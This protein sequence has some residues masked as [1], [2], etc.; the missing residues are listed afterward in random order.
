MA[1]LP[2]PPD[3]TDKDYASILKR[4]QNLIVQVFARWTDFNAANFGNILLKC[5]AWVG[6][7]LTFYQDQQARETRWSTA[8]QRANIISHAKLID[9]SLSTAAAATVLVD[10]TITRNVSPGGK[11]TFPAGTVGLTKNITDP[12]RFQ[13]L[14]ALEVAA[15][16]TTGQVNFEH[17]ESQT[18]PFT[19]KG[20]K[21]ET[22]VLT[23]AP[24]LD[25]SLEFRVDG[26]L[27]TKV[28]NFL[29]STPTSTHY[30]VSVDQYDKAT[31]MTGDG[32][33][34]LV[35]TG[36]AAVVATYKTGGGLAGNVEIGALSRLEI[37]SWQDEYGNPVTVSI[38]NAAAASGGIDRET[39]GQANRQ[40]PASIRVPVSCVAR[41]DFEDKASDVAG[42]ARALMLTSNEAA[43]V[44]E[45][46]GYMYVVPTG[47]GTASAA[48]LAAVENHINVNYPPMLT[49]QW[50]AY[51]AVYQTVN[52]VVWTYLE[53]GA[54][55]ATVGTA[56]RTVLQDFF[57]PL[58][59]DQTPNTDID[60]G[61]NYKKQSG[62]ADPEVSYSDIE[63][64]IEAVSGVR[65]LGVTADARGMT[66]NAAE[67]NVTL[68]T[69]EFPKAGTLTIY[70]GDYSSGDP[71]YTIYSGSIA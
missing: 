39:V 66:L 57:N 28:D 58:N 23:Q 22:F 1:A 4:L 38:T 29:D 18:D 61:Y 7:L 71:E 10:F 3:Y 33:N 49:F 62:A 52:V 44:P 14:S 19:A 68:T 60:F 2:T 5:F 41:T 65:K 43:G 9:Y 30:T 16:G 51:T 53:S 34:G 6:S 26:A 31:V 37:T 25:G 11:V 35:P 42:V 21:D 15:G 46:W 12:E 48:L 27:W 59:A 24:Y 63:N 36:G 13:S 64:A 69:N 45:N 40:A 20:D 70:N 17:S 67:D 47:G 50:N 56:I 55:A 8:T 54:V 32:V